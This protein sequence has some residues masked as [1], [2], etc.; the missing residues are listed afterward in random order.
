MSK[1]LNINRSD[2]DLNK[3]H[4]NRRYQKQRLDECPPH[5]NEADNGT[6]NLGGC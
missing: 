6:E 4:Y 3:N 1:S 2:L 5:T